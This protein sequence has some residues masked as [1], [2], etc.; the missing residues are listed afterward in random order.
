MIDVV[1]GVIED[2]NG[3]FLVCLR[4]EGKHLGG[5][6]EFPGGKVDSGESP[7]TA[8][9]RELKE[10]LGIEVA[11][12]KA[13]DPVIWTYERARIRLLPFRC[14][15]TKGFPQALEHEQIRWCA[16]EEF[17]QLTWADA[18]LPVLIQ[19]RAGFPKTSN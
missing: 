18:D 15:I 14:S 17:D 3:R 4:P 6:W 7:E 1:C 9:I 2:R 5:L 10:E 11:V 19:I 13:L 12:G 8:L 16:P